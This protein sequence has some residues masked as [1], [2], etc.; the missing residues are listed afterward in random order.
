M[1]L[2]WLD[3]VDSHTAGEP[4]RVIVAGLPELPRAGA[5]YA[6]DWLRDHDRLRTGV[7]GE[8]RGSEP[9]VGAL[10][11]VPR[12]SACDLGVLFFNNVG[13]LGMCGHGLIGFIK[14]LASRGEVKPGQMTVETPV[15][16]VRAKLEE[17]GAVS[18]ANVP[19]YR[20]VHNMLL[21]VPP[22]GAVTLDIAWGGNWFGI[23]R[24][25]KFKISAGHI[26]ELTE[27][28]SRIRRAL[29]ITEP[30]VDHIVLLTEDDRRNFV[31][32]PGWTHDRSPCGTGTSALVACRV[33]DGLLEEGEQW[34]QEGILG[35]T[36]DA[37]VTREEGDLIP[38][39]RGTAFITGQA[40]LVFEPDDPMRWGLPL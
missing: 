14:T 30:Q 3:V 16:I 40:R 33:L 35:T 19:A 28:T 17:N 29:N 9:M 22:I 15:G 20:R 27:V 11:V 4:T 36:F 26:R 5:A 39:V 18:F 21:D 24:S 31:L 23:V 32:C 37:W 10:P 13:S 6:R 1:N 2:G 8:P 34:Q 7:V 12:E 38:I 25:P